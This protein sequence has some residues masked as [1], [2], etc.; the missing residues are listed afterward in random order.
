MFEKRLKSRFGQRSRL[1]FGR[2]VR[3]GFGKGLGLIKKV[4]AKKMVVV[5]V[6]RT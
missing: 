6:R 5:K 4:R 3:L 1:D 2:A